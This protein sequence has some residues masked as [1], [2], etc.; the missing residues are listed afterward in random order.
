[1]LKLVGG[2]SVIERV[3]SFDVMYDHLIGRIYILVAV[4]VKGGIK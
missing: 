4:E 3:E 1:M 2:P